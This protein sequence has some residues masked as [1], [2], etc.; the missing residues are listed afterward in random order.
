MNILKNEIC[1]LSNNENNLNE[2]IEI[3]QY[4]IIEIEKRIV[5]KFHDNCN[6]RLRKRYNNR[7]NI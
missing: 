6:K 2:Q 4:N 5:D 1:S 7:Y 3:K